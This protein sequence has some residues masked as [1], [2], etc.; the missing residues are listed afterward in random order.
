MLSKAAP[1]KR[2]ARADGNARPGGHGRLRSG[3]RTNHGAKSRDH[4]RGGYRTAGHRRNLARDQTVV[5][6]FES[7][8]AARACYESEAYQ[9]AAK[10]RQ[11]AADC[12]A[13]IPSGFEMPS[14]SAP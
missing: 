5:L 8:D 3:G 7:V 4:P 11:A 6:E 9:R 13:V 14:A 2:S 12:N 10:L 1:S